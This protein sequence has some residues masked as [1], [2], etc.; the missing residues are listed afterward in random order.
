MV[1]TT[2]TPRTITLQNTQTVPLS[3][4]SISASGDFA[5]TLKCPITPKT[6]A[7]GS[8]CTISVTFTPTALGTRTG[9]LSV[10]DDGANSPQTV[11]LSGTGVAPVSF[12]T[13]SLGFGDHIVNTV[14]GAKAVTLTNSQKVPLTISGITTSGDFA[15]STS[16]PVSPN[17]LAAR[18]SCTISVDFTPKNP[19][20]QAGFLSVSDDASNSPQTVQL[21]GT[22]IALVGLSPSSINFPSQ[23][24]FTTS[25]TQS[26]VLKNNQT[27]PLT[28][29]GIAVSGDFAEFSNCPPS[30]KTLAAGASCRIFASFTPT[31]LGTRAG[32]LTVTDD[33]ST[34]PQTVNL[35][36][37]GSLLSIVVTP[38][39]PALP[40]GSQQQLVA[41]GTGGNGNTIDVSSLV[42]WSSA[43]PAIVLVSSTG[44]V[45]TSTQ[46][47]ATIS[48]NYGSVSGTTTVTVGPPA[49]TSIRLVPA[50]QSVPA[51]AYEQFKATGTYTD[52][53]TQDLTTTVNWSSS[54]TAIATLSSAPGNQGLANAVAVGS[55]SISGTFGSITGT[56]TLIVT[57]AVL[58]SIAVTPAI[59]S[60][61]LGTTRQFTATGSYTDGSARDLSKTVQWSSDATSIATISNEN[62]SQGLA[63]SVGSGI[64]TISAT[65][66]TIVGSTSLTVTPAILVSIAVN[67]PNPSLALGGTQKFTAT[68][69]FSDGS[70]Q[71]LTSTA[72]WSSDSSAVATV[73][74]SGL[75][76]TVA[77]GTTNISAT[78]GSVSGST[79]LAVTASALVSITVSPTSASVALGTTEQFSATGTFADGSSQDVTTTVHWSSSDGTVATVSNASGTAGVA[80]T[81]AIGTV[82]ILATSDAISGTANLTVTPATLVSIAISPQSPSI[83]LGTSQQ[84]TATGKFTDG[85][86]QDLTST[87]T[88]ASSVSAVAVISNNPGSQGLAIS[89]GPGLTTM[90]AVLGGVTGPTVLTVTPAA[91]VSIAIS[92]Q[93]L[94]SAP[95]ATQQFTAL[96]MFTDGSTQDLTPTITWASSVPAVAAISNNPGSQGLATTAGLGST[97][98][99]ATSG[100]LTASTT[101]SVQGRL[102][103]INISP[104]NPQ[105]T[106]G[107]DQQFTATGS[108]VGGLT[109]D[110]TNS[111]L[112]N[113]SSTTV[114][115]MTADGLAMSAAAGQTTINASQGAILSSVSLTVATD[116]LGTVTNAAVITCPS[117]VMP[118]TCYDLT[119]SC[120][121]ISDL[122]GYLKVSMPQ[123][124]I[125]SV[126]FATGG[127]GTT[128]LETSQYGRVTI[129]NL[130]AANYTVVRLVWGGPFGNQPYGWQT[131][132]GGIRA[133][134]CR[135]ATVINWVYH[136]LRSGLSAPLC[137]GG[138]SA[139]AEQIGLGLAHYG[140]GSILSMAELIVG[141]PF[142]REDYSCQCNQPLSPGLCSSQPLSYCVGLNNA[143][144]FVDPAYASP[145]CSQALQTHSTA[146]HTTFL[147]DSILSPDAVLAYPRTHIHFLWGGQDLS[148]ASLSGQLYMQSITSTNGYACVADAPHNVFSVLDAAQQVAADIVNDC[149]LH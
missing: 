135:P 137:A 85:S 72:T 33:A 63:S 43:A 124:S 41:T 141:P 104:S 45:Q 70:T 55:C 144:H 148:S 136:N 149:H 103:S 54:N 62:G 44:L 4:T 114:A 111:V 98:I 24:V 80:S 57:P 109:E 115:T 131:G 119:V 94:T 28:I 42:S 89:A 67:P 107:T 19:G 15:Q 75:A 88:W 86:T 21:S 12:S 66:G 26:V 77:V 51:G 142:A 129:Q 6:L 92:P 7:A 25:A 27:V 117:G 146:N 46:G 82:S 48:A 105:L 14:S 87:V 97:T 29:S 127:N 30:P 79:T 23:V 145:I 9:I 120:P 58:V 138:N 22:G 53:S 36:G 32:I 64:A 17:T 20:V 110:L 113:S 31:S 143:E 56:T 8:S 74:T 128:L 13:T 132:P 84:L 59:P 96:G 18:S 112:W 101:L 121:N 49:L 60:I 50:N 52:G 11:Q 37:T 139:G 69:T 147:S 76:T 95:G 38:V 61:P 83:A 90:T 71:D 39:N 65:S 116:R 93:G 47:V 3:I 78:S 10:N 35:S 1:Q 108:Y 91:L 5:Q 125:G 40:A 134:A 140:L 73:N 130:L 123:N 81:L 68:G 102:V 2:S 100:A 106:T 16:C 118:G 126:V 99:S 122:H 34:S 133:V